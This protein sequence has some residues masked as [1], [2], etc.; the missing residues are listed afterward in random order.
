MA[1]FGIY[2]EGR[3]RRLSHEISMLCDRK[4]ITCCVG[5][6]EGGGQNPEGR[7]DLRGEAWREGRRVM[8]EV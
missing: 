4:V 6:S 5:D 1:R 3:T 7:V 8:E 2:F